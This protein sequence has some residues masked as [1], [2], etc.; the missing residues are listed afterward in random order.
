MKI[1]GINNDGYN[2]LRCYKDDIAKFSMYSQL[3]INGL[4][5]KGIRFRNISRILFEID[6]KIDGKD[7]LVIPLRAFEGDYYLDNL[8]FE[9]AERCYENILKD[10]PS[11]MILYLYE[12]KCELMFY[13]ILKGNKKKLQSFIQK[14]LKSILIV[15]S[16]W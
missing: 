16:I 8:D 14:N 13:Q 12:T 15:V 9:K 4:L 10:I 5:Y 1:S 3:K 7:S 11:N 2:A 6:D